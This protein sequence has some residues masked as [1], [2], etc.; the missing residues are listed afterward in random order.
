M[1][2]ISS[3]I[4]VVATVII[5]I[6]VL[7]LF[8]LYISPLSASVIEQEAA[9]KIASGLYYTTGKSVGSYYPVDISS[10]YN[11][12]LYLA[13]TQK[14]GQPMNVTVYD[15]S[16]HLLYQGEMYLLPISLGRPLL[17]EGH[18]WILVKEGG[19]YYE[20]GQV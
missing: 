9:Q 12:T 8:S 10:M 3:F 20:V 13:S 5:G 6:T 1:E 18:P 17:V 14:L 16:G 19:Q 15:L 7:T 4:L 2:V 11:V